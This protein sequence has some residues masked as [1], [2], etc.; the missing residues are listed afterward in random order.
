M[1]KRDPLATI[2]IVES[3]GELDRYWANYWLFHVRL[4]DAREEAIQRR[5]QGLRARIV[6][7]RR[8]VL[9]R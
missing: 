6:R 1:K 4:V 5:G 9:V 7:Y 3:K 2:Y 8:G